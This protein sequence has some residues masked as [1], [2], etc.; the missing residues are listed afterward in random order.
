MTTPR[1]R[2]PPMDLLTR[3]Q[4]LVTFAPPEAPT[5]PP[6]H[7]R[8]SPPPPP[9]KEDMQGENLDVGQELELAFQSAKRLLAQA[10]GDVE[11]PLNQKAQIIGAL[12]TVLTS[13]SKARADF[14]SAERNRL[15]EM[16]LIAVLKDFPEL[17]K[18][19]M[20]AYEKAL[21]KL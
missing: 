20:E 6:P 10:E 3:R 7:P 12:N 13:I 16:T 19:F 4:D 11:A 9:R 5:P 2:P 18:P 15:L 1:N 21:A 17:Q 14:Y 8:F